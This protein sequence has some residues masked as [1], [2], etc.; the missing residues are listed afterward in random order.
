LE[1]Y[2]NQLSAEQW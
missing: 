2:Q 1:E